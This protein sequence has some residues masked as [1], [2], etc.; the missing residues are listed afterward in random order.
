MQRGH[1]SRL[2]PT[3]ITNQVKQKRPCVITNYAKK[4]NNE[5]PWT[6]LAFRKP[7][8]KSVFG[9]FATMRIGMKISACERHKSSPFFGLLNPAENKTIKK[10]ND[11]KNHRKNLAHLG[12]DFVFRLSGIIDFCRWIAINLTPNNLRFPFW[13]VFLF[14]RRRRGIISITPR[15]IATRVKR[16]RHAFL[17]CYFTRKPILQQLK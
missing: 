6:I 3:K 17:L 2:Q 16:I 8:S 15:I 10:K 13:G 11:N 4:K 7:V 5:R 14:Y 9:L 12:Q 1:E